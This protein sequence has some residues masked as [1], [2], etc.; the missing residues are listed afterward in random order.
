MLIIQPAYGRSY[1]TIELMEKDWVDGKDFKI[2][3]GPYCSVRDIEY[4]KD[5]N[6]DIILDEPNI[7]T[8]KVIY[9]VSIQSCEVAN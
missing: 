9:Q 6:L 4:M 5:L 1:K 8:A 7:R 2:Q 3:F